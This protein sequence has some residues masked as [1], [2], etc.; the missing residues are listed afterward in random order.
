MLRAGLPVRALELKL[1]EYHTVRDL[2]YDTDESNYTRYDDD[3]FG[4]CNCDMATYMVCAASIQLYLAGLRS[5]SAPVGSCID[6]LSS[7]LT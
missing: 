5:F 3:A 6:C 4:K 1:Y 7:I 2:A